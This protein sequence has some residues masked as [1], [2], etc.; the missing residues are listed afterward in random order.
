MKNILW[1]RLPKEHLIVELLS[2]RVCIFATLVEVDHHIPGLN[3]ALPLQGAQ[4]W[5]LIEKVL[6]ATQ[7]GQKKRNCQTFPK[8]F[9]QFIFSFFL[10]QLCRLY[11]SSILSQVFKII[12]SI[13][14]HFNLLCL[15]LF[16]VL[17]S[18]SFLLLFVFLY[19]PFYSLELF[20][21]SLFS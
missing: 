3:F 11:F 18:P 17:H 12:H 13:I 14:L 2:H 21:P 15:E 7:W 1:S 19:V 16:T 8:W 9:Y 6:H 5:S 10:K 4:V 20:L